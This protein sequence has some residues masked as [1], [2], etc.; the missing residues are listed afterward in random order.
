VP[1]N[2]T[3]LV[4]F[5]H[6]IGEKGIEMIFQESVR[7]N[8]DDSN[9]PHITID[10]TVQE[11][12]ITYPTDDKLY[13]KIIDKCIKIAEQEN[14][15]LRQKY[16]RVL[17][18]LSIAQR[19][20]NHPKNKV[21]AR[22]ADKKVKTIAGRLVRDL[23]RK[24]TANSGHQNTIILFK[25]VLSQQRKDSNKIYSIH[26]P[27]VQC[28]SKGKEHKKYEF[29]NKVSIATTQTT[30]VIVGVESFRNPYDG[31]TLEQV[32]KHRASIIGNEAITATV[33][34]GCKGKSLIGDTKI[35][36]PKPFNKNKLTKA[37]QLKMRKAFRRRAAIEPIIS[38]LKSDH[39]MNRNMYKG[40]VGDKINLL[41]SAAAFNF[42]RM[43]NIWKSSFFTFFQSF[44]NSFL[45]LHSFLKPYP[46]NYQMS[47]VTF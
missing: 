22:K 14:V 18:L 23:E 24:L 20:R 43:M 1:C 36:I 2:A 3:E 34:R 32:L 31:H 8:G 15:E 41:L 47:K 42:K 17:K 28:I 29:G 45:N 39:R 12:N 44:L 21:K 30:G 19:F 11:K 38:H 40:I 10:T 13:K 16:P 46:L 27:E 25:K 33:D 35:Q 26:E 7:I 9:D 4:H 5:R 37:E 6:R